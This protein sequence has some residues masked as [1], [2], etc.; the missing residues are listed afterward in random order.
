MI[1][2]SFIINTSVEKHEQS[3]NKMRASNHL[4]RTNSARF[5]TDGRTRIDEERIQLNELSGQ[6]LVDFVLVNNLPL[7]KCFA[8]HSQYAI[9]RSCRRHQS[10]DVKSYIVFFRLSLS[11]PE[12]C[13]LQCS[14]CTA[15]A[16][17][18]TCLAKL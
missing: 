10:I 6:A 17:R 13:R 9:V 11:R 15:T 12:V 7:S 2:V 4:L 3:N 8:M 18:Q 1:C 16:G 14:G 5:D